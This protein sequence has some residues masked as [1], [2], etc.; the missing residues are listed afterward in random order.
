[1]ALGDALRAV[2]AG[3]WVLVSGGVPAFWII[4]GTLGHVLSAWW[5]SRSY[6]VDSQLSRPQGVSLRLAPDRLAELR[7]K[8]VDDGVDPAEAEQIVTEAPDLPLRLFLHPRGWWSRRR[9]WEAPVPRPIHFLYRAGF[10]VLHVDHLPARTR[11]LVTA[12][13]P[14]R[15][16]RGPRRRRRVR[17]PVPAFP[18]PAWPVGATARTG[19]LV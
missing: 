4:G 19:H 11:V 15:P 18:R 10:L 8:M 6:I 5:F 14:P 12:L 9:T 16:P 1:M 3:A 13:D 7:Q 2:G 17:L